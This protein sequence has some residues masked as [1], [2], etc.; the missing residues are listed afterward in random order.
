MRRRLV[1]IAGVIVICSTVTGCSTSTTRSSPGSSVTTGGQTATG[2]PAAQGR[3]STG[4]SNKVA[5]R[6]AGYEPRLV[7]VQ[8][9][10]S[11]TW[12]NDDNVAHSV[13][14]TKGGFDLALKRGVSR[15]HRFNKTGRIAY[16]CRIHPANLW[17]SGVIVVISPAQPNP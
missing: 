17:M 2:M 3:Q 11:V 7:E 5:I 13:T 1:A 12:T 14:A 6:N 9:G 8:R 15:K 10:Q 4:T 16:Y